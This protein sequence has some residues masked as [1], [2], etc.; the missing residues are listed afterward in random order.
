MSWESNLAVTMQPNI[1][2]DKTHRIVTVK[3]KKILEIIARFYHNKQNINPMQLYKSLVRPHHE[4]AVQ[5]WRPYKQKPINLVKYVL[6]SVT[7]MF[8]GL[9]KIPFEA[10]L[11][12]CELLS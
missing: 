5:P 11:S 2:F 10:I 7:K 1:D 6:R 4:F 8:D 3:S 12:V 9:Y